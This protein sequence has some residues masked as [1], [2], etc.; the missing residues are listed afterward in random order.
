M[1][2]KA[3]LAAV[4][5]IFMSACSTLTIDKTR[6]TA[7]KRVAIVGFSVQQPRHKGLESLFSSSNHGEYQWGSSLGVAN[8]LADEM[9]AALE[10]QLAKEMKWKVIDRKQVAGNTFYQTFYDDKMK[11]MQM[12]PPAPSGIVYLAA[13]GIVDAYPL[14]AADSSRRKEIMKKLN[15]DAIAVATVKIELEK[16]GG[17]KMLV[18]AGDYFPKA[19][20][21]FSVFDAKAEDP[22]WRD[23]A[24]AGEP[25]SEGV[26][27]V[28]G[29]APNISQLEKKMASA[30][31]NSYKKLVS[32]YR[33]I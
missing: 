1:R 31:E 5:L 3:W 4:P 18:G 32:R 12:R 28:F 11:G 2:S 13:N 14:E 21:N 23:L 30:A 7:V 17:L 24:A 9:Y 22:A 10:K 8:P 16:G 33:D 20:V 15:V 25:V 26:E 6:T 27:H 19:T 29:F